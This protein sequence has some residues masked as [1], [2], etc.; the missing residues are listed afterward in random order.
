MND[1]IIFAGFGVLLVGLPV[2]FARWTT[3]HVTK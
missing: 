1:L 3:H 2:V